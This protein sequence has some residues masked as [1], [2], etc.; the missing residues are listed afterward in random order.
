MAVR[1]NVTVSVVDNSFIVATGE[2]R[3]T[4]VS[5]ML[6]KTA[7]AGENLVDVFGVT[8]EVNNGYMTL[9][10]AGSW[11]SRL[12]GISAY[13]GV[14]GSGPT[15]EWKND[16]Y[17][18]YN[19]L[20]YGGTLRITNDLTN[21]YDENI[22]LDSVF[23]ASLS[24]EQADW[25]DDMCG[26]RTDLVGI[27]GVTYAGYEPTGTVG[28]LTGETD[29]SPAGV[30][31]FNRSNIMLVGGEKVSLG[32]SNTG[33]DNYVDILL[34]G[35]AAGCMVRTDREAQRWFSP[36]G[37]RRGRVLNII[38]LKK[39]PSATEQD[40]LYTAKINY[41][42]GVPGSGTYLFGDITKE[43]R[44][45]STLTRINVVR[46]INYIKTTVGRTAQSV[47]FEI[48]DDITRS[49]FSNATIGF[50]QDIQN[51]RG[52]YGFKVV[53]DASNNPATIIDSNQF[54]ADL[55]I[56]PTKSINY[57]K[58][59]ITNVNTDAVL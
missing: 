27:V 29:I 36:A 47:L 33:V 28:E 15:G 34:A 40:N 59:V 51:G 43:T 54:V 50:L 52:L 45:T 4:H 20:L 35:D 26:Q 30:A 11:V 7:T 25:V 2:A 49:L 22:T 9:F 39:N 38:R 56:K 21:L 23:T 10:S 14:S 6:S 58:I 24:T 3:G 48:N 19:Y 42:L 8:A 13:G 57:V 44:E 31:D 12:N 16:W 1:P 46:L 32:L 37:V 55:Y 5:A 41:M 18:A 53:C 17:A